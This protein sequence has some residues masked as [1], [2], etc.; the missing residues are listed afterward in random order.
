MAVKYRSLD[1]DRK[2][3]RSFF[4]GDGGGE[5]AFVV[6][7]VVEALELLGLAPFKKAAAA[8][9]LFSTASS[10]TRSKRRRDVAVIP[11]LE[12]KEEGQ[13][14]SPILVRLPSP[15]RLRNFR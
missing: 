1:F 13:D 9:A 5:A 10:R 11:F 2:A 3:Y 7:R 15:L 4:G 14:V 6:F 12:M 8:A